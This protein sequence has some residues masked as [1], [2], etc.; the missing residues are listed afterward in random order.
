[1]PL[2]NIE[3]NKKMKTQ[4]KI[5]AALNNTTMKDLVLSKITNIIENDE[6]IEQITVSHERETLMINIGETLK[7]QIRQHADEH[8]IK[9]KDI[10]VEAIQQ[11]INENEI[12]DII[13]DEKT[14]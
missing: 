1:M 14:I 13:N 3:I 10:W 8:D 12:G 6:P 11:I 4:L 2:E 9:I 5:I 7:A